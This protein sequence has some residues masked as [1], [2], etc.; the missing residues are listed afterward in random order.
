MDHR[1]QAT[2]EPKHDIPTQAPEP[3]HPVD[4][5]TKVNGFVAKEVLK[6]KQ[7]KNIEVRYSLVDTDYLHTVDQHPAKSSQKTRPPP[8]ISP[9]RYQMPPPFQPGNRPMGGIPNG[10]MARG[11]RP[12]V[13]IAPPHMHQPH[14]SSGSIHFGGFPGST[15]SSPAPP[16][17]G[18]IAPPPGMPLPD[19]RPP[20][21]GLNANGMPPMMPYGSD[22]GH[23][24]FDGYGRP[25]YGP[26]DSYGH[27]GNNFGP[28]TPHSFHDSQTSGG[29]EENNIHPQYPPG[30][31]RN[32]GAGAGD[33]MKP[34]NPQARMMGGFNYPRMMN[35]NAGI[36]PHMMPPAD[37][38][39]DI[40]GFVRQQFGSTEF[41]D[42]GLE[43]RYMDD[44]SAPVRIPGHRFVFARSSELNRLMRRQSSESSPI[45]SSQQIVLLQT[46]NKWIRSDSFYMAVQRLYGLPLLPIPPPLNNTKQGDV[47][48][49]GTVSERLEFAL[50]YA[51]AGDLLSWQSV[52][53]RGIE[54]SIRLLNW[55]TIDRALEFALEDYQDKG[56]HDVYRYG[57]GSRAILNEVI[58]YIINN[59]PLDF[60][61]DNTLSTLDPNGRLPPYPAPTRNNPV[62]R[63]PSV[64]IARGTAV[65]LGKNRRSQQITGI[66]FGDLSVAEGNKSSASET[67]KTPEQT[68]PLTNAVLT[69]ALLNI[70][71]T[72]LKMALETVGLNTVN[73]WASLEFRHR[74]IKEAVV[75]RERRRLEAVDAIKNGMVPD[76]QTIWRQLATPEPR[77]FNQ[78]SALGW[79]E[80]IVSFGH[81]DGPTLVRRW[82]PLMEPHGTSVAAYP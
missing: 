74:T 47:V 73:G 21:M 11:P 48:D 17:S 69:R 55:S 66:Q 45:G 36:P 5:S 22:M 8:T 43:L 20:Y 30:L 58:G 26:N 76:W 10:D 29:P 41:A 23:A 70:P 62:D 67:S 35:P 78:W 15:T 54:V 60:A 31:P 2:V 1:D 46:S 68:S 38:A 77:H 4:T 63:N 81:A 14:P 6:P 16:L 32:G 3:N 19:G 28:S 65:R 82:V 25:M 49:A 34:Q 37:D 72:H 44:R 79:Q 50:S 33:D 75:E 7:R 24:P 9:T 61:M 51:A 52:A 27:Y 39:D 71:F 53:R 12:P 64:P 56:S 13:N 42:C 57:E 40:A 59:L 18:G 80:E